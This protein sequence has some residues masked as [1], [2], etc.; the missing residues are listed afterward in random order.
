M[1]LD[2]DRLQELHLADLH[3]LREASIGGTTERGPF[4]LQLYAPGIVRLTI[5]TAS[6]P[7]YWLV[8]APAEPPPT[9]VER[10]EGSLTLRSGAL[11]ARATGEDF[12]VTLA[13]N[14]T[15]LLGPPK[16]AHFRR[17]YRLPRFAATERGFFFAIDLAEGEPVYGHGEKWSRLDHRGQLITSWNED[18]LGVNAEVSYKNCPFA[19]SPRGWGLFVN[20][21]GRVVHGVGF[22]PFSHRSYTLE[23]EDERLDLF[24]IAADDPAGVIERFTWLTGRP[25]RVPRWSL[26]A[27][28]S[29]AYYRDAGE[30][31]E[32]ARRVRALG[33]PMDVITLDGRAWQDTRTRFAFQWDPA[34]YPEPKQ[35]LD[36]A[37]GLGFRVCCWEYPLVSVHSPRFEELAR[38]GFLLKDRRT[39]EPWRHHWD[40]APFGGVLTPLP[41]S[42]I[43]DFTHPE[44]YAWWRDQHAALFEVGVDVIKSDFG[45]QIPDDP[46]CVA[47][48]GDAGPRLHNIYALLY[49]ACVF[50]ARQRHLGQGLVFARAGWAGSQRYPVQWGGDP[51]ADWGGL[52]ASIRGKLSWA[53][54]GNPWYATDIG[55]FYGDQP[56]AELFVRWCQA[57]VFASH[58]RFHGIG[59]REPWFFGE[60]AL[61]LVR[62]VLELRYALIPYIERCLEETY[63]NGVPLYR[64]MALA[65]PKAR[66][67]HAFDTQYLFGP[68]LLVAPVLLPGGRVTVWLPEGTWW[69]WFTG[70]R[71]V[72]PKRL[73]AVLPLDRLPLF[74][75]DGTAI[76]LA[77]PAQRTADWGGGAIPL[78]VTRA[79]G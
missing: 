44:A 35:V 69:D 48:N 43:V 50:E 21:P 68:D 10:G 7:D 67:A 33:L 55:G 79:F 19:W 57:A 20:T 54:S 14:G 9:E 62:E 71:H 26:G 58:M 77:A 73:D 13:R 3:S 70:E 23:V 66:E 25:V 28:L 4:R 31:L 37:K 59:A 5:G 27:W 49:N 1:R 18:A 53:C 60:A 17:R 6:L 8:S 61:P 63:A 24:L 30:F 56:D 16:D 12:V 64:P 15:T 47:H 45:E 78:A 46:N 74:A 22:A 41:T 42:G 29:K 51:Q 11:L 38:Q 34:R 40:P 36:E 2:L 39:G 65:F 72:G 76:P 52:A 32:A 75:R